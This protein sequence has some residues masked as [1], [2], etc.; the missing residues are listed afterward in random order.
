MSLFRY[1]EA[2]LIRYQISRNSLLKLSILVFSMNSADFNKAF[3]IE[4][5]IFFKH[6]IKILLKLQLKF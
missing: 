1:S 6:F 4:D 5:E 3:L 2:S